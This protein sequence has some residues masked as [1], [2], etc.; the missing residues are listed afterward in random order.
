MFSAFTGQISDP[1]EYG[2]MDTT[3]LLKSLSFVV[4]LSVVERQIV[5]SLQNTAHAKPR[6]RLRSS[7][8]EAIMEPRYRKSVTGSICCCPTVSGQLIKLQNK[9]TRSSTV[10]DILCDSLISILQHY[11]QLEFNN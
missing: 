1:Y 8:G 6:R 4:V 7:T 10:T 5:S 2:I 11:P 9:F 3:R